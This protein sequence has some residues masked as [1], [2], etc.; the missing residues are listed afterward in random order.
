[1]EEGDSHDHAHSHEHSHLEVEPAKQVQMSMARMAVAAGIIPCPLS[2]TIMLLAV[3]KNM[4][5]LGALT[6]LGIA[7]GIV[8][9]LSAVGMITIKTKAT[10]QKYSDRKPGKMGLF[11]HEAMHYLGAVL[12]I[13]L[14]IGLGFLYMPSF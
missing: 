14:G 10:L 11:V 13:L 3:T 6:V 8:T 9:V 4:F 7:L 1:H 12:I 5:F 2:I